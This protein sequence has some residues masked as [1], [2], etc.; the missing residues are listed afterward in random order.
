MTN[1]TARAAPLF[2]SPLAGEVDQ[3]GSTRADREGG[4]S[5]FPKQASTPSL[6]LPLKGGVNRGTRPHTKSMHRTMALSLRPILPRA[7]EAQTR[8]PRLGRA[9]QA[10]RHDLDAG[11]RGHQA[12]VFGQAR[13]P[14]RHARSARLRRAA[15]CAR[16]GDQDR[17][18]R[19]GRPQDLS[20]HGALGR[21]A[22]HRRRRGPRDR[23]Q[24][25]RP[26]AE[27]IRAVLPHFT[28]TI[29]Q[30]PPQFSAIKVDGERAYDIAREGETVD[31]E[32]RPVDIHRLA[33]MQ[34]PDADH[35]EF[36][37][38]C[39][40]GT[41]VR[42][43]ARD[44]GRLLGCLGHVSALR[45][46]RVGPFTESHMI[47]LAELEGLCHRAAPAR[48]ASPMRYCPLRPRWTTSRRWPS[49][50][51]MRQ[52]SKGARPFCCADG[53]LLSSAVSFM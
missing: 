11:G 39:G 20:F 46:T 42:A 45:R 32:P 23:D 10:G 31:L 37:A 14:C 38:E 4:H 51:Q 53:T 22:R 44:I 40:K 25:R 18:V 52:G 12:A 5:D 33:L 17:A 35:S 41:Y 34:T 1:N 2:T 43:L 15:D 6:S 47:S 27:A 49:V 29:E 3:R 36:E 19:D 24:R 30:V 50:G 21:G 26:D 13:R 48:Q 28:G 16:R 8:R 7:S 9:R